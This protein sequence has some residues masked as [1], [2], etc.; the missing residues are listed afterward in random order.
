MK[1][2]GGFLFQFASWKKVLTTLVETQLTTRLVIC[3]WIWLQSNVNWK[4]MPKKSKRNMI[5][6]SL[7]QRTFKILHPDK[8]LH[9]VV[10]FFFGTRLKGYGEPQYLCKPHV[11]GNLYY[12]WIGSQ[13]TWWERNL[14]M[15][16]KR[17]RL[18]WDLIFLC[19]C[20]AR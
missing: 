17:T 18:V 8:P 10:V 4:S 3:E 11:S 9:F 7:W 12:H 6:L 1:E 19:L 2:K 16:Q 15:R 14:I 13:I 20:L 5:S